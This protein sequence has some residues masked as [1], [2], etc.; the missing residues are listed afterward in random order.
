MIETQLSQSELIF[1][2][3]LVISPSRK[4]ALYSK[5]KLL[6]KLFFLFISLLL[7][8]LSAFNYKMLE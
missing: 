6:F 5:V 8:N 7:N 3:V 2:S 1:W 4:E